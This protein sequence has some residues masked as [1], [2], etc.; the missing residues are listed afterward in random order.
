M[1]FFK[2]NIKAQVISEFSMV[3]GIAIL[4]VVSM[5]VFVQ[6]G[7][8]GRIRDA[9]EYVSV[10]LDSEADAARLQRTG[11]A[12]PAGSFPDVLYGYEPYYQKKGAVVERDANQMTDFSGTQGTHK[13]SINSRTS[14]QSVSEEAPAE[15]D[16]WWGNAVIPGE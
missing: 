7:L 3:L 8:Q 6:R 1:L 13:K 2:K 16:F 4:A 11:G 14:M 5:M 9:R 12:V 10:T 15:N